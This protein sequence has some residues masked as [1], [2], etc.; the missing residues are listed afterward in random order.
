MYYTTI[1]VTTQSYRKCQYT[2]AYSFI[3]NISILMLTLLQEMSLHQ[4]YFIGNANVPDASTAPPSYVYKPNH[5]QVV[6]ENLSFNRE[7]N[8]GVLTAVKFNK[9]DDHTV[10][11]ITWEVCMLT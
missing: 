1:M 2:N 3:G 9:M 11:R 10:L 8:L 7:R 6:F 5:C 4:S